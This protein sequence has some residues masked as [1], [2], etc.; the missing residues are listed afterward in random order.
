MALYGGIPVDAKRLGLGELLV[1]VVWGPIMAGGTYLA[2][3]GRMEAR[4][5]AVYLPYAATVSLGLIGKHLDK[6][7]FDEAK[8]IWTLPV[9]MGSHRARILASMIAASA[10]IAA[11]AGAYYYTR[12]PW[13]LLALLSLPPSLVASWRLS[14]GKP[15]ASPPGWRVWPLWYVAWGFLSLDAVGRYT[16][17]ALLLSASQV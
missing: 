14:Q 10:P 12:S 17:L 2:L 6:L 8:G 11:A 1:A 5:A 4:Q 13:S 7:G 15:R 3:T 9:R 16:I